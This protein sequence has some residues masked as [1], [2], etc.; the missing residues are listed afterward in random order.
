MSFLPIMG[1]HTEQH[2]VVGR[3]MLAWGGGGGGAGGVGGAVCGSLTVS[4]LD[5]GLHSQGLS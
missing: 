2:V 5:R 1:S 3:E 4:D